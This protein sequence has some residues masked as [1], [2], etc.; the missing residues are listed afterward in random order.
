[1]GL[2]HAIVLG[3]QVYSFCNV[4]LPFPQTHCFL[5]IMQEHRVPGTLT[6]CLFAAAASQVASLSTYT[7]YPSI[8]KRLEQLF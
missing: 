4:H 8:R 2:Y 5:P 6:G 1:M 7:E 3:K